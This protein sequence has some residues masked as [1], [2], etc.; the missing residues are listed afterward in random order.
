[1][2]AEA[3]KRRREKDERAR[4][5]LLERVKEALA[6]LSRRVPFSRT[7][8]FGSLARPGSFVEGVSDVDVA[9]E[10]LAEEDFFSALAFLS[11]RLGV[12]V[13]AVRLEDLAG[14]YLA[15]TVKKE[16]ILWT[17]EG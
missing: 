4:Q 7:Y 1:M 3:V 2:V 9:F 14:S 11:S 13:D 15:A 5:E 17:R 12:D 16:G 8:I 10:G 6:A